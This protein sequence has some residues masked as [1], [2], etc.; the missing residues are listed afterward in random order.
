MRKGIKGK[1]K[2]AELITIENVNRMIATI[3]YVKM[4]KN[5]VD[6]LWN[7]S[8]T[9]LRVALNIYVIVIER[10]ARQRI[11]PIITSADL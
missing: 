4:N 6:W 11:N 2:I 5:Y 7:K 10:I 8:V 9:R 3:V 1:S